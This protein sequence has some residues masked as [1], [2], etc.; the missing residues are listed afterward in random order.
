MALAQPEDLTYGQSVKTL[1]HAFAPEF[2]KGRHT[3]DVLRECEA[4]QKQVVIEKAILRRSIEAD[5]PAQSRRI[6]VLEQLV[7]EG[8][9]YAQALHSMNQPEIDNSFNGY[10]IGDRVLVT[11][12]GGIHGEIKAFEPKFEPTHIVVLM[13]NGHTTTVPPHRVEPPKEA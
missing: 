3:T 11:L 7:K 12:T 13:D 4:L 5:Q 2:I 6:S 10:H 8:L 9:A 1:A